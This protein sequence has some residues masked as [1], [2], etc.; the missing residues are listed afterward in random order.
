[1][2]QDLSATLEAKT[3]TRTDGRFGCLVVGIV[4]MLL[5]LL[6][7]YAHSKMQAQKIKSLN[8]RADEIQYDVL[9]M[10]RANENE[11]IEWRCEASM[12]YRAMDFVVKNILTREN[13]RV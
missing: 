5:A 13:A 9:G 12:L 6:V 8:Q 1:M 7:V 11:A 10:Q 3:K 2:E 4:F